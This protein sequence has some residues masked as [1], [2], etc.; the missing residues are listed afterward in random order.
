MLMLAA[1]H[2]CEFC[3]VALEYMTDES[4]YAV[5]SLTGG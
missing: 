5:H 2:H 4:T 1:Q 3:C